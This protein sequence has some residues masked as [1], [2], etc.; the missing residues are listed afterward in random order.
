MLREKLKAQ[1]TMMDNRLEHVI[2]TE[3]PMTK[4]LHES[5]L[6]SLTAGGKRLRPQLLL[7]AYRLCGGSGA[8]ATDFATAIEMIHTYSL[9]HD[10]L[11]AMDDDDYRRGKLTNHKVYGEGMAVL[12]GDGLLN[13]AAEIMLQSVIL[14]GGKSYQLLAMS[15]ILKA[16][17]ID[18][19]IAGQALDLLCEGKAVNL[20]TL[21]FIHRHKTGALIAA[22]LTS[23]AYL[24][25]ATDLQIQALKKYGYC[26]G[27]SFQIVDDI[28]DLV[29]DEEKMGKPI[30]S[31]IENHKSTYPAL[32]GVDGAIEKAQMLTQEALSAIQIFGDE[33]LFLKELALDMLKRDF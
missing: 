19:M 25:D 24:A 23:G 2:T 3:D 21:E 6:Y 31:D 17:G 1:K 11:P 16:S 13:R 33:G 18:G 22:A 4:V 12:A 30:G 7:E 15:E 27:L 14:N 9:I 32:L 29:G 8:I 5:M 20:D 26:I 10:D 28:L